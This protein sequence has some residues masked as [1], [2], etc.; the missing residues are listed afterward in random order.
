MS[1]I[2]WPEDDAPVTAIGGKAFA[3]AALGRGG[4]DVP[5]WFAVSADAATAGLP[6]I[7]DD[8]AAAVA[9]L[10]PDGS[11][12][13]VRSSAID[14]D[15]AGHSFAGQ[16]ESY[17][18]VPP[19]EV[20]ARVREVWQSADA[21][22][23]QT[24]RRERGLEGPPVA[25]AVIV[26]RMAAPQAA[27][28]AFSADP[29]SGRRSVAVVAAVTGLGDALV[30]GDADADA[31]EVTR[32]GEVTV[33]SLREGSSS[34]VLTSA[35]VAA[36]AALAR[37]CA[38]HFGRPQDI[39]WALEHGRVLLLQSRPITTL[40]TLADPDGTRR[41]WDNSNI[42]ESYGGITTPLTFSFARTVYAE[43]YRQFCVILAVPRSRVEDHHVTFETMLGSIR[44]RVYYNLVSWYRV[45][46]LLPGFSVNRR[47]MEQMMGVREPMPDEVLAG[48]PPVTGWGR[49]VD[50]AR[51][52]RSIA[53]LVTALV[54]LPRSIDRFYLRLD[55]ALGAPTPLAEM[56][57]DALTAHYRTL[58]RQLLTRWDAPLVNDFFA[59]IFYGVLRTLSAKWLGEAGDGRG[60]HND[61]LVG[62][63]D[64][65]SAEPA[66]RLQAMARVV[67]ADPELTTLLAERPL[68]KIEAA[69]VTSPNRAFLDLYDAYLAKFSDRCLDELKLESPTL[70]DD[71]LM[72]LRTIGQLAQRERAASATLS[73]VT[74]TV[75]TTT[76]EAADT[77]NVAD[78]APSP[79]VSG[80]GPVTQDVR[81]GAEARVAAALRG[82]PIRGV[83]FRW[84]MGQARARVR[85]RE[86][87]RFERTRVFGRVRR[88]FVEAGR[89][90]AAE[91]LLA[92][93]DDVFYL[94]VDEVLGVVEGTATTASLA[95]LADV[96]RREYDAY[97]ELPAPADRFET[98]GAVWVGN[99][100]QASPSAPGAA[101]GGTGADAALGDDARRGIGCCPGVVEGVARV[102]RDPR[103][104]SLA[105]GDILVAERTDPGWILLFPAAAAV[106]VERGSVLSH[107]AIVAR[108]LGLPAVVS[109]P[110]LT[111]WLQTGDRIAVDG[112]TG[113]V[114]RVSRA[115]AATA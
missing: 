29:V 111:A 63:G 38:Q 58:E 101:A 72:L 64:I 70:A 44:G 90:L 46:A 25:P 107:S 76:R 54:R 15:G 75:P 81:A 21:E 37:K 88:I 83:I 109:L 79:R 2:R 5:A 34:P 65:V 1:V 89:R 42:A 59:M 31:Y 80:T 66:R 51:L 18:N 74:G 50:G 8:V 95:A 10:A 53:G 67:A 32:A 68:A 3:L 108:E 41:I 105:P 43:V 86:N 35:H 85:H 62:E 98:R 17:L 100:F 102:I 113:I 93:S 97:R 84:V 110:G 16:F 4:F 9:R 39:E 12:V 33:R 48:E 60:L 77:A 56:R 22:R 24:Y 20:L 19:S 61:L 27:G 103:G 92:R 112:S 94:Q 91:G 14:E 55:A 114:R 52:A 96:R 26:Q 78:S 36:V 47:F 71:P 69:F 28:V 7:A 104:A 115:E 57:L 82:R 87:L 6:A 11:L 13:A 99:R 40:A 45:L 23:V 30:S 49:V 73:V 106:V